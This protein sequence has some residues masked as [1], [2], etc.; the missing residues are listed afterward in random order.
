MTYLAAV[1]GGIVAAALSA[2][3]VSPDALA[4]AVDSTRRGDARSALFMPADLDAR[5]EEAE[6]AIDRAIQQG[7][8]GTVGP[9]RRLSYEAL[10]AIH[11]RLELVLEDVLTCLGLP[12][13]AHDTYAAANQHLK[14]HMD[15]LLRVLAPIEHADTAGRH[16][17]RFSS[18]V[19][20]AGTRRTPKP[21]DRRSLR[22]TRTGR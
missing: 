15:E 8:P 2:L 10:R 20:T 6:A 9:R 11:D 16:T 18:N 12:L 17:R 7:A 13:A 1:P 5:I 14:D 22:E 19:R 3:R 21:V 4:Q